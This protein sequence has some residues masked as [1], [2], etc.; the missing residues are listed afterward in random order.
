MHRRLEIDN[1]DQSSKTHL[2][3]THNLSNTL[4]H[5]TTDVKYIIR[6]TQ[7]M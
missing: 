2:R 4:R 1:C 3:K 5:M 7:S 6:K